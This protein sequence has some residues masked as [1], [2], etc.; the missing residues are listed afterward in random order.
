M[1]SGGSV[2]GTSTKP[3]ILWLYS[4]PHNHTNPGYGDVESTPRKT[5]FMAFGNKIT[6][7]SIFFSQDGERNEESMYNF[8][9]EM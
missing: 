6:V 1:F 9:E 7:K 3:V 8:Q 4:Q 2:E 5:I